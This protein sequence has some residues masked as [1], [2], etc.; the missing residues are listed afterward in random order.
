MINKRSYELEIQD[1]N[2]RVVKLI[3]GGN[4]NLLCAVV[5]L[6]DR[7]KDQYLYQRVHDCGIER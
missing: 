3:S 6:H 7:S 4:C 1:D 5:L 2:G